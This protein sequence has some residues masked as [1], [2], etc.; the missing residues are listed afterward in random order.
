[1][2][3]RI[4]QA[5]KDLLA[6][7]ETEKN[8]PL[9]LKGLAGSYYC[10]ANYNLAMQYTTFREAVEE[11]GLLL[12]GR[13]KQYA[14]LI[15][16]LLSAFLDGSPVSGNPEEALRKLNEVREEI[17]AAM[18]VVTAY[19]DKLY[20]YEYVLRRLAPA[21]ENTVEDID[22]Y[23]FLEEMNSFL[24]G[25]EEHD[26]FLTYLTEVI[27]TLPVRMTKGKFMEWVRNAAS[28]YKDSNPEDLERVFFML[29]SSSGLYEP[30]GMEQFPEYAE[31]LQYFSSLDYRNM[32]EALYREAAEKLEEVTESISLASE[33]YY[34][35]IENINSL[36][37]LFL[38]VPY[39]G[40]E[41]LKIAE[42]CLP[43]FRLLLREESYTEEE[44]DEA[45]AAFEG[46]PEM[47]DEQLFMEESYLDEIPVS[48]EMISAMMQDV[49]YTR[50]L[51]AKRLHTTSVF[52]A[53]REE[54]QKTEGFEETLEA[55][56]TQ[57]SEVLEHGERVLNRARMSQVIR[58]LPLPFTARSEI[59]KYILASLENCHDMSEKTAAVRNI[60]EFA[61]GM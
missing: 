12:K 21:M 57:L 37:T 14:K 33:V 28:A 56:C 20:L 39:V 1:M 13:T 54:E 41:D 17:I 55:F 45:F 59:Q 60:R 40:P 19:A 6:G 34:S 7:R 49:L 16:E 58:Q 32:T 8:L 35:L 15:E 26:V 51:Y 24:F 42:V 5:R 46:A 27:S 47:L 44:M 3:R 18:Y 31:A 25:C 53:I 29:Y 38:T 10:M 22:S 61:E 43:V 11:G 4:I 30:E 2:D 52:V 9:Y 50:L 23:V 36:M 48:K